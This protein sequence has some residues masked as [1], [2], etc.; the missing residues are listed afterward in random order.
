ML[1]SVRRLSRYFFVDASRVAVAQKRLKH[2]FLVF[3]AL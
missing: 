2:V 1:W 3:L